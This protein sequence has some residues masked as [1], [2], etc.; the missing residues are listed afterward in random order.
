MNFEWQLRA[1]C[2]YA[3]LGMTRQSL[4]E[5]NAID[6][7]YQNRPEVLQLRLHHLMRTHKWAQALRVSQKLCRAAPDCSAGFLHAGFCLHELGKTAEAKQLLLKGP[8]ALLKEPIYYY[9]M[10]CY[11]A[12]LGNVKDAR[13]N[14]ETSFRMDATFRELAKKDPDLKS[15]QTLI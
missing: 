15:V 8:A 12:L 11:E 6:G 14:L 1:A 7:T 13:I 9:N 5:L 2:G 4:S 10:G 3:E